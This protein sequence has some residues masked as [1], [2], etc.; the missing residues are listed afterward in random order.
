MDRVHRTPASPTQHFFCTNNQGATL[1]RFTGKNVRYVSGSHAGVSLNKS[2]IPPQSLIISCYTPILIFYFGHLVFKNGFL[3]DSENTHIYTQIKLD[4]CIWL[5]HSMEVLLTWYVKCFGKHLFYC[6]LQCLFDK[7]AE[8]KVRKLSW[9]KENP[10][11]F[12]EAAINLLQ[13][14]R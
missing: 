3:I 5:K 7:E 2:I 8:D 14:E 4:F 11:S 10:C 1:L 13:A 6:T 9:D 12:K